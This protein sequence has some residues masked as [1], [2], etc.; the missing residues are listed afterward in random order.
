MKVLL[1]YSSGYGATQEIAKNIGSV[2]EEDSDIQVQVASIDDV[3]TIDDFD[4]I[5]VGSSVR[6]DH[7]TANVMDF[8]ALHRHQ[9]EQKK[10]AFFL[11]C[12][13][14]NCQDGREKVRNDYMP[15]ILNK[16]PNLHPVSIEA[17][18]GKIDFDKLNPVMQMLMERVLEKT[19]IPTVGSVDTR[20]WVFIK[21]WALQ[22]KEK[23]TAH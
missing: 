15:Y 9:L 13:M 14:A 20:D 7:P 10:I 3:Q 18:G 12:L 8:L 16:Y 11:V 17:F 4:A 22:L 21:S 6:A 23:L 5:V 19:G 2:L 1:L